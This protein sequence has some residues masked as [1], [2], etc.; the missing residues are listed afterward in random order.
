MKSK[1][2]ALVNVI[3]L[4]LVL[5]T[6][7]SKK[8]YILVEGDGRVALRYQLSLPINCIFF[9]LLFLDTI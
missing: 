3:Y 9:S 2:K 1:K 4:P 7:I 5:I 8:T 6:V